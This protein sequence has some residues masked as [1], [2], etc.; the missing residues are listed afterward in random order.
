VCAATDDD[1]AQGCCH[2]LSG[3]VQTHRDRAMCNLINGRDAW[4]ACIGRNSYTH[5]QTQ[6]TRSSDGGRTTT[7]SKISEGPG[8]EGAA[9]RKAVSWRVGVLAVLASVALGVLH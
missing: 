4:D 1:V 8:I 3:E 6:C 9:E 5:W 7:W 2:E